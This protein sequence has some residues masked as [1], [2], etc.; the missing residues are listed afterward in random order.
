LAKH[1]SGSK[2]QKVLDQAPVGLDAADARPP[3]L[4]A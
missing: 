3:S 1:A 4:A 2:P